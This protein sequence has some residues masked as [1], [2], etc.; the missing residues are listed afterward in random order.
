MTWLPRTADW[1][2]PMTRRWPWHISSETEN[3]DASGCVIRPATCS[4]PAT[5]A[6]VKIPATGRQ[7]VEHVCQVNQPG[8]DQMTH[9]LLGF[10]PAID[11]QHAGMHQLLALALGQRTPDH[12]IDH[13]MLVFQGDEGHP[14][15][16]AGALATGHQ[17]GD[18][19]RAAVLQATQ[20]VRIP[21]AQLA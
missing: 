17:P 5:D 14:A 10:Q 20:F 18:R 15:G 3:P 1:F 16:S 7:T 2:S 21:A 4:T 9:S 11:L 8:G 6:S 12:D 13:A 19:H